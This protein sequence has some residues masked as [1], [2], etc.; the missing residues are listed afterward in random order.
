M[1]QAKNETPITK[2]RRN[3]EPSDCER[4]GDEKSVV[5][6]VFLSQILHQKKEKSLSALTGIAHL[7]VNVL[8]HNMFFKYSYN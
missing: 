7:F 3:F 4:Q 1:I 8:F 6:V 2:I 5:V